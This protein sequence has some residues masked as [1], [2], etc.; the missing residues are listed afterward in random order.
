MEHGPYTPSRRR[1][2]GAGF[3]LIELLVVI[4]LIAILAALSLPVLTGVRERGRRVACLA[5]LCQLSRTHQ[6][7]VSDH[8]DQLPPWS[9]AAPSTPARS[10]DWT[11][12]LQPYLRSSA[13]LHD[14]SAPPPAVTEPGAAFP[15]D[16]VLLTW[17][18]AG[19]RG[20][21]SEPAERWPGPPLSLGQVVRPTETIQWMDGRT[22]PHW[23][24]GAF[25]RH[26][27]GLNAAF[28][29]GHARWM[30]VHEYRRVTRDADGTEWLYH[31]SADR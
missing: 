24:A 11:V 4:G 2:R 27:P 13:V 19:R 1:E 17:E 15:A 12:F 30:S 9:L 16:Y 28:V 21:P 3:T 31:G 8:D 6:L 5:N 25:W 14:P 23:T 29:D 10:H 7:Y 20:V 22:A 18:K 26:G